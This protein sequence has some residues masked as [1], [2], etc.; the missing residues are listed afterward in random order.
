[1]QNHLSGNL[2]SSI[3]TWLQD[4]EG[5]FIEYNK[6][7]GTIPLSI[8]NMSKLSGNSFVG[9]VPKDLGNLRKLEFLNIESN[10]FNDEHLASEVGFHTSLTNCKSLR[11]LSVGFNPLK[12]TLQNSLGNLPVT[13][14]KFYASSCQFRGTI[15]TGIGNLTN[16]ILLFLKANHLTG[17]IPTVLFG[18]LGILEFEF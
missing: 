12:S 10:Q 1:M 18:E 6:F 9:N 8:S 14:E 2:P 11:T 13:L 16:L 4:L 3:G 17:S 15:P 7:S 5:L